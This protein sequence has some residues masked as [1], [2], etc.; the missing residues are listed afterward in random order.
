MMSR[1]T[2]YYQV[3]LAVMDET[4]FEREVKSLNSVP[5]NFPKTILTMDR[6]VSTPPNGIRAMNVIDW[7]LGRRFE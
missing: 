6:V 5:D 3:S 1:S 4:T 7:I 2:E